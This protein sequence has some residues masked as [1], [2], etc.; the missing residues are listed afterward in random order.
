[1]MVYADVEEN[2]FVRRR[3]KSSSRADLFW[4][5]HLNHETIKDSFNADTRHRPKNSVVDDI[6]ILLI[7]T[8]AIMSI[9][10]ATLLSPNFAIA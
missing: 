3:D 4:T 8:Y 6:Q 2:K 1:M 5:C 10:K 7:K 9:S